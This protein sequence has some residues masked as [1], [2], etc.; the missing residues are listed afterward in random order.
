MGTMKK[1][2]DNGS[3]SAYIQGSYNNNDNNDNNEVNI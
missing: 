2:N 1:D 3:F